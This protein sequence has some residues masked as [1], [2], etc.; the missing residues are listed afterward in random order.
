MISWDSQKVRFFD[1]GRP[2]STSSKATKPTLT[3]V[4]RDLYLNDGV[5][6]DRIQAMLIHQDPEAIA[7]GW[8]L[9]SHDPLI[10][11]LTSLLLTKK[12]EGFSTIKN[13]RLIEIMKPYWRGPLG[14]FVVWKQE[15]VH[16][17]GI[18]SLDRKLQ[19]F[20]QTPASLCRFSYRIVIGT[21]IPIGLTTEM[22]HQLCYLCEN[23]WCPEIYL[24]N[25]PFNRGTKVALNVV[26][27]KTTQYMVPRQPTTFE[28]SSLQSINYTSEI[29]EQSITA[30][31]PIIREFYGIY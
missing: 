10:Q 20:E 29:I 18:P 30:L 31:P 4:H 8:V 22:L 23:G 16:Y 17:E 19:A 28:I 6:I 27:R 15:T 25:K 13:E 3:N 7:L 12:L 14:G 2:L 5:P 11:Q 26:N 9:F 1:T 24:R 21:H